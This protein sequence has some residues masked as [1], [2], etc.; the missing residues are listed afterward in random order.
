MSTATAVKAPSKAPSK[1]NSKAK[2]TTGV[3]VAIESITPAQ[4]SKLLEANQVNRNIRPGVVNAYRRDME[5]GRWVFTAEPIQISQTKALLNGQ[6]RLKALSLAQGVKSVDFLVARG[7]PDTTQVMM[8]QGVARN[9]RDALLL[10]HGHIKNMNVVASLSRWLVLSPTLGPE[11]TPSVLRNKVTTAEALEVFNSDPGTI[12]EAAF[13]GDAARRIVPGSPTALAYAWYHFHNI[14]ASACQEF[15][16]GISDME[17]SWK[18]DPRKAALR[19]LQ[20]IHADN[21]QRTSIETGV[22][23][24]SV[25]TRAWNSWRKQEEVESINGRNKS[26]IILPVRPI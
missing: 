16:A 11:L 23:L 9:I 18:N 19:R 3:R 4:A 26:G 17:W 20:A 5:E 22:I 1:V 24:V 8:D 12:V 2:G 21:D 10:S 15:F 7:L 14:D 25:L 6:H 13:A